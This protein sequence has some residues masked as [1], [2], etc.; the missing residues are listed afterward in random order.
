M[1]RESKLLALNFW[2]KSPRL[3]QPYEIFFNFS[4]LT[5]CDFCF[6]YQPKTVLAKTFCS[7][8][9]AIMAFGKLYGY[10]VRVVAY[11]MRVSKLTIQR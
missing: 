3:T 4:Q 2:S 9:F 10:P 6:L 5:T 8:K 1:I 7:T 11:A